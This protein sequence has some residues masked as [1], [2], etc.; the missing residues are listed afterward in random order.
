MSSVG[1]AIP[2]ARLPARPGG[3][4]GALRSAPR[5][6]V[7]AAVLLSLLLHLVWVLW[8]ANDAGDLSAQ[9]AWTDFAKQHPESAYNLS[10][11]G[12]MHTAS[13]SVLSPYLMGAI[14]VRTTGLLAGVA[15]AALAA[16]LLIRS[17]VRRPLPAALWTA[18]ALWC[19]VASGRVTFALG[20]AFGLAA[21]LLAYCYRGPRLRWLALFGLAALGTMG[22]PVVGLFLEV[23]GAGLFLTGRRRDAY[24]LF[25]APAVV[26]GGTTLLFPFNGMQ[27][28]SF[29][30]TV[31]V[32]AA[33]LAAVYFAPREWTALRRA[34]LVYAVG[35]MLV[36]F[37]PSPVG[38]NVERLSL[39]FAG[40]ALLAVLTGVR[41]GRRRAVAVLVA[42]LAVAGWLTGRTIGDLVVT[43]PVTPP[44][45]DGGALID[46][47]KSLGGE[48][49]RVEVVPLSSHWEASGVAPYV[50]L[51][52]GWN[53][54]A[55]TTRNPLF[56]TDHLTA[57]QYH[58]WLREW[59]VGYVALSDAKPDDAAV[60]E[61][62]LVRS[63]QPYLRQVWQY[64]S[65]TV[66]QV[67]DPTPLA[68]PPAV[69][70]K[71]DA[72]SL[73][74]SVPAAGEVRLKLPYSPWL[75]LAG[76]TDDQHGCLAQSGDWTVLHATAP[77]TY[78]VTGNYGLNRGTPC[79]T[80]AKQ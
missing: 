18:F 47:L 14:G 64:G 59:G 52:R 73:T 45:R 67:A 76:H 50:N 17:G 78:Q 61:A 5:H 44:A 2:S 30:S 35:V 77:G 11:Y 34:G 9:Y 40:T 69:V 60:Q 28:F 3:L 56:Y 1:S 42:F 38:S 25:A 57:D 75:G 29:H 7:V 22:S 79:P 49:T 32:V 24:P 65:W 31:P 53:R 33:A 37:V 43:V 12:G 70:E 71:A 39:L 8:L 16:Q 23:V 10:W 26:V 62:E 19:D 4:R 54:Q 21:T 13:Y 51:A 55:D 74:V 6:P 27:P 20:L 66:Y 15:S 63:G 58:D 36:F 46:E 72:A 68:D 80:P 41:M 48:R